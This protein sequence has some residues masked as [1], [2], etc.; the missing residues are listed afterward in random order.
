V[1][2]RQPAKPLRVEL[3]AISEK[4]TSPDRF[5]TVTVGAGGVLHGI[6][7]EPAG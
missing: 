5:V 7:I 2:L 3:A 6:K 1:D 4:V